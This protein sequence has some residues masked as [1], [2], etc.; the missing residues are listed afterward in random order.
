[1]DW[2]TLAL[3]GALFVYL[4]ILFGEAVNGWT[5]APNAIVTVVSTG[6][7]SP[8]VAVVLAV[9]F[10]IIG[11]A[12]GLAVAKTISTGFVNPDVI[13]LPA[14]G[15]A[16]ASV[17]AWGSF[18]GIV[19]LPISKSH[20][21]VASITGAGLACGGPD[22]L[23]WWGWEA[24]LL[25]LICSS[26]I[27]C[28]LG[29]VVGKIVTRS[30]IVMTNLGVR[31]ARMKWLFDHLQMCSA[32][33]MAWAHG[34]NDGQKFIGIFAF[35][36]VMQGHAEKNSIPWWVILICALTMGAG[37]ALG[38]WEIMKTVGMRMVRLKSMQGFAAEFSASLIIFIVSK[39]G[40]PVSTT[41]TINT[42]IVG[43]AASK[44]FREVR[45]D[46]LGRIILAW[47]CTFQLCGTIAFIAALV[48]NRV[49]Q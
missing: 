32:T 3:F 19:G 44:K 4:L 25:G 5:D 20:A 47:L 26:V 45:Y 48:A 15:A 31:P 22:A 9:V 2:F 18:A 46:V 35:T 13:T 21:L 33:A 29:F 10:N 1:M 49:F 11:A 27:G 36:L 14:I 8:R 43:V 41:H 40:I 39:F 34:L 30:S 23:V 38:G 17:I 28:F 7:L 16:M 6:V 37:T 42:S 24:V 12:S